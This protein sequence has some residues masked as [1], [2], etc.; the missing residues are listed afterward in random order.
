MAL[1]I[2]GNGIEYSTQSYWLTCPFTKDPPSSISLPLWAL[3]LYFQCPLTTFIASIKVINRYG[4]KNVRYFKTCLKIWSS[5]G[6]G[7]LTGL[8]FCIEVPSAAQYK[9]NGCCVKNWE[10]IILSIQV[11][12]CKKLP[13]PTREEKEVNRQITMIIQ[14]NDVCQDFY[15]DL[16]FMIFSGLPTMFSPGG[17]SS[18]IQWHP[19]R[20]ETSRVQAKIF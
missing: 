19:T 14:D 15:D 12:F 2:D 17:T 6:S 11:P 4:D 18:D 3:M 20:K 7:C 13:L 10:I 16:R 8:P 5:S 1:S 9:N